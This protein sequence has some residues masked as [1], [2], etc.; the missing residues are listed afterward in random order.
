MFTM[1]QQ[2]LA[3]RCACTPLVA[4]LGA[5]ARA[6]EDPEEKSP[7]LPA[8][9]LRHLSGTANATFQNVLDILVIGAS[10]SPIRLHKFV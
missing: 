3:S 7:R 8:F 5:A 10:R 6:S 2:L 1:P 4:M 9:S